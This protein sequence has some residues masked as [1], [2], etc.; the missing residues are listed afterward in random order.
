MTKTCTM[1]TIRKILL[2]TM[3][4]ILSVS[5][6][7]IF[8]IRKEIRTLL[9]FK[10]IPDTQMYYMEY[11]GDYNIDIAYNNGVDTDNIE[12]SVLDLYFP[13]FLWKAIFKETQPKDEIEND[14][15]GCSTIS[16]KNS[17]GSLFVGRNFDYDNDPLL[18]MNTKNNHHNNSIAIL[19][20]KFLGL[21]IENLQNLILVDRINLL[22]APYIVMDGI[23][24]HG[25]FVSNLLDYEEQLPLNEAKPNILSTLL[26]RIILD[27]A[28]NTEEALVIVD[29]F[30]V[31][32]FTGT[33]HFLICDKSGRSVVV[34]YTDNRKVIIE[35]DKNWQVVTNHILFGKT[36]TQ[37]DSICNRYKI[38]SEYLDTTK[39]DIN[40]EKATNLM[41]SVGTNRTMWSSI[42]NLTTG[43]Y[44]VSY[45][46]DSNTIFKNKI[47]IINN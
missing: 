10:R 15:G 35:S 32:F 11:Y 20:L 38:A 29:K 37:N 33:E 1:K 17:D 30:N 44:W 2:Y 26:Y 9:S 7:I 27:Y 42:Y 5:M 22:L 21:R 41:Y 4:V 16:Y 24:E 23:N 3:V 8:L 31:H 36:E 14:N 25:V 34:E 12:K 45:R 40:F 18:I 46:R 13:D 19:D 43:N 39:S 28:K 47:E 6:L